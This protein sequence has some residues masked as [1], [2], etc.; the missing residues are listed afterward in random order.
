MGKAAESE[1]IKLKAAWLGAAAQRTA[2]QRRRFAD[3]R[4]AT[5]TRKAAATARCAV[6]GVRISYHGLRIARA[7][8][9]CLSREVLCREMF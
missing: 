8:R 9:A 6:P 7:D 1:R 5:V 3:C 2:A 4:L